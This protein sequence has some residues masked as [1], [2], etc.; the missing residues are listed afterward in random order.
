MLINY[1]YNRKEDN[2]VYALSNTYIDEIES[3][4]SLKMRQNQINSLARSDLIYNFHLFMLS[5]TS[6]EKK[7]S[8]FNPSIYISNFWINGV[9]VLYLPSQYGI[10]LSL[11]PGK[12]NFKIEY[13]ISNYMESYK[14]YNLRWNDPNDNYFTPKL[15]ERKILELN[16]VY[17]DETRDYYL[18]L[19]NQIQAHMNV[20]YDK[21]NRIVNYDFIKYNKT[22]KFYLVDKDSLS[23]YVDGSLR[24]VLFPHHYAMNRN[25]DSNTFKNGLYEMIY[26]KNYY[27]FNKPYKITNKNG[28]YYS[29]IGPFVDDKVH[30]L[31]YCNNHDENFEYFGQ[32]VEG[33]T[34]GFGAKYYPNGDI[35]YGFH[36]NFFKLSGVGLYF[37]PS[38]NFEYVLYDENKKKSGF[39]FLKDNS[40]KRINYDEYGNF[41][42][43][44]VEDKYLNIVHECITFKEY[45]T[46]KRVSYSDGD[47]IGQ[48]N[49]DNL[50]N[51]IGAINYKNGN[52]YVGNFLNGKRNGYGLFYYKDGSIVSGT[53][54]NNLAHGQCR[55]YVSNKP[56]FVYYED[57]K[58]IKTFYFDKD[59]ISS[60]KKDDVKTNKVI[61]TSKETVAT[62]EVNKNTTSINDTK[63]EE[64][65]IKINRIT[66]KDG[67]IYE[68]PLKNNKANGVGIF[69]YPNGEKYIGNIIDNIIDGFGTYHYK[70]GSTYKGYF[71]NN[72]RNGNG[73]FE[74]KNFVYIGDFVDDKAS[75]KGEITYNNK[76]RYV[77]EFK[78]DLPHGLG[79]YYSSSNKLLY[80]GKWI[81][82]VY[83]DPNITKHNFT[84][85][86]A[87][88]R[89]N[90]KKFYYSNCTYIGMHKDNK[91]HLLGT[92]Y[93]N[94]DITYSGCHKDLYRDNFG[95]LLY[96]DGSYYA[97]EFLSDLKA[98][99]GIEI[100]DNNHFSYGTRS[101]GKYNGIKVSVT[102][103]DV[104]VYMMDDDK[105]IDILYRGT[106]FYNKF[107]PL[108]LPINFAYL[109]KDLYI[110]QFNKSNRVEGFGKYLMDNATYI[111][112]F[113][114]SAYNGFGFYYS[115]GTTYIAQ[116]KDGVLHGLV[117][118]YESLS[119]VKIERY[120]DGELIERYY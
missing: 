42:S 85:K 58:I 24:A 69:R 97:G 87:V 9:R 120:K 119:E 53:F 11:A 83:D 71:K 20:L 81:K 29:Y 31:A 72:L 5:K 100:K 59:V 94:D 86:N 44:E 67:T 45:I 98:G 13:V 50:P 46:F 57:N 115:E 26:N 1:F 107:A 36:L 111:G 28:K 32:F 37:Y 65:K 33:E 91:P 8:F 61:N 27:R 84:L 41:K 56:K 12:Y 93:F 88:I 110:G 39:L 23:N 113:Y 109:G 17:I 10:S 73:T 34:L 77:G 51:G 118:S 6:N 112:E 79:E 55:V 15:N 89:E 40:V 101:K 96:K 80:K 74:T 43:S 108:N 25:Y 52:R 18:C 105:M 102:Y 116:F 99:F 22:T 63:K 104:V 49:D 82:G 47:Y 68:G 2:N 7:Y 60:T 30:G 66:F 76:E 38:G 16:D 14:F 117:I 103:N 75:G 19:L 92:F 70:D 78:D 114:N 48:V 4:Y 54:K 3:S 90:E 64:I 62:K 106:I 95:I 21:Y 35:A